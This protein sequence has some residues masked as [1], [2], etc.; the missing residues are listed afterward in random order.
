MKKIVKNNVTV[1]VD[2]LNYRHPI[3]SQIA[4][5]DEGSIKF[6]K[7]NGVPVARIPL[8]HRPLHYYAIF[9]A[10]TQEEAD[11]LNRGI[12][13]IDRKELRDAL[14]QAQF[15]TSYEALVEEG[16]DPDNNYDVGTVSGDFRNPQDI[17]YEKVLLEQL[18]KVLVENTDER[19]RK[20]CQAVANDVP[21]RKMAEVMGMAKSTYQDHKKKTLERMGEKLRNYK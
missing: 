1:G 16:Y 8:P 14:K 9:E 5:G 3:F 17:Y 7:D 19:Q 20:I 12:G 4:D 6:Y 18:A 10:A 11:R 15:E 13:S 2:A 21:D